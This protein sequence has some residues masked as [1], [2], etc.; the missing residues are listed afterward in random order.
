MLFR[1]HKRLEKET[2]KLAQDKSDPWQE[3]KNQ[4]DRMIEEQKG[5]LQDTRQSTQ[6]GQLEKQKKALE[7]LIESQ[8]KIT[9]ELGNRERQKNLLENLSQLLKDKENWTG[10]KDVSKKDEG[11]EEEKKVLGALMDN[12][13]KLIGEQ[14]KTNRRTQRMQSL[15]EMEKTAKDFQKRQ[16]KAEKVFD[17]VKERSLQSKEQMERLA[18]GQERMAKDVDKVASTLGDALSDKELQEKAEQTEEGKAAL[19]QAR[20]LKEMMENLSGEIRKNVDRLK[21]GDA[22]K[23]EEN[24]KGIRQALEEMAQK[25]ENAKEMKALGQ[26]NAGTLAESQERHIGAAR[27]IVGRLDEASKRMPEMPI[28]KSKK[29]AEV[30]EKQMD[31]AKESL[32]Q[33]KPAEADEQQQRAKEFLQAAKDALREAMEKKDSQNPVEKIAEIGRAHV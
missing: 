21:E 26:Q 4:I 23:V 2:E 29:W 7:Q 33:Q 20:E 32:I 28:D 13:D 25:A 5:A 14:E 8:E 22:Q 11:N 19:K 30:A 9:G 27:D 31:K 24:N 10:A 6:T 1:S 12:L 15:S 3:F 18:H 17:L 16:E